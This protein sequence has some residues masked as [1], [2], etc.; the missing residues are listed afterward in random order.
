L[1]AGLCAP[2]GHAQCVY[3]PNATRLDVRGLQGQQHGQAAGDPDSMAEITPA[4]ATAVQHVVHVAVVT[5]Y[6]RCC[7]AHHTLHEARPSY[8]RRMCSRAASGTCNSPCHTCRHSRVSYLPHPKQWLLGV[9]ATCTAISSPPSGMIP[10]SLTA[11]CSC[12]A[13]D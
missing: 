4:G 1:L 3:S 11:G 6:W 13:Q 2:P 8:Q 9:Y 7:L 5:R 10:A 12:T